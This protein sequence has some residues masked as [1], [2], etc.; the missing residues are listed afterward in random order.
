MFQF[1]QRELQFLFF[2][3]DYYTFLSPYFRMSIIFSLLCIMD[4]T[5]KTMGGFFKAVLKQKTAEGD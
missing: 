4:Q 2:I 5:L 3:S 1:Q